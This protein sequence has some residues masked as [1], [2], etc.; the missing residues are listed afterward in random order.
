MIG[1][2][3]SLLVLSAAVSVFIASK[4]S[5]RLEEDVSL[6]QE[7]FRFIADRFKKDFSLVAYTG[8]VTPFK[9]GNAVPDAF[10]QGLSIP[11]V[12]EGVDGG[13]GPDS[14]TVSYAQPE[15]GIPVIMGGADRTSPLYVSKNMPLYDVLS[16]NFTSGTAVPITLLVSNCHRANIFLVTGVADATNADGL[17]IGSILHDDVTV[18]DGAS[19]TSN[20]LSDVYGVTGFQTSTVYQR[21]VVTY[22]VETVSGVTGLYE[23]RAGTKQL[24]LDN[25]TDMQILYGIDSLAFDGNANSYQ[26]W[27]S[28]LAVAR[29][30]SLKVTLTLVVSQQ[31]GVDVTRDYTFVVK[32]R[33]MGL[34]V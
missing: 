12:I 28:S 11:D 30:T 25:I 32:L 27:S 33:D 13:A 31:N 10:V 24:V 29:I 34:D 6:L 18:I 19:N 3:L 14:I 4:E 2:A 1:L 20:E 26:D 21:T 22:A 8:C 16:D 5:F 9:D 15:S 17:P 7:N 23:T